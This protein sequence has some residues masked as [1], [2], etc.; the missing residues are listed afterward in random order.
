MLRI[1][2]FSDTH[3]HEPAACWRWRDW[4]S[5]RF[6]GWL[7]L[8]VGGRAKR[9]AHAKAILAALAA[10]LRERRPDAIVFSGDATA[11]AFEEEFAAAARLLGVGDAKLPPAVAVPGN[12]DYYIRDAVGRK[13]FER[14]FA[15]WQEGER[16]DGERYPFVRRVGDVAFF[17]VNSARANWLPW[18]ARGAVGDPQL[19]RLRRLLASPTF[20]G[21]TKVLVTHYPILLADGVPEKGHHGLRDVQQLVDAA[22]AGGVG[23]WLH[24]HRHH[25][26]AHPAGAGLPFPVICAGSATQRGIASYF[27]YALEGNRLTAERRVYRPE[28][29]RFNMADGFA[30]SLV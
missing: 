14:Y 23:L 24:G 20:A 28:T 7:N 12:H 21:T 29:G 3:L 5:K 10:E 2:H 27:E 30:V 16:L 6:T 4:F 26:Y 1:A 18:D 19:E 11:L 15:A 17:C 22:K 9:F 8:S 25:P 13:L